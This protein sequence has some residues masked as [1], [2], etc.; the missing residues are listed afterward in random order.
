M[1]DNDNVQ[2]I[3]ASTATIFVAIEREDNEMR[4]WMIRPYI[5]VGGLPDVLHLDHSKHSYNQLGHQLCVLY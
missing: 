5:L 1:A 3:K 4:K 2:R